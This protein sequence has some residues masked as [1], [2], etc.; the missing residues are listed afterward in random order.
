MR[1]TALRKI[2]TFEFGHPQMGS[3]FGGI[4]VNKPD[5]THIVDAG[6]KRTKLDNGVTIVTHD[7]GGAASTIGFYADAGVRYDPATAPGLTHLARHVLLSSNL[8]NA[9]FQIDRAFRMVGSAYG[10]AEINKRH[11]GVWALGNRTSWRVAVDQIA[12]SFAAPRYAESDNE[13]YRDNMDNQREELRWTQPR[14]YAVDELETVAFYKEPLGNPRMVRPET[15]DKCTHKYLLD[16]Y[17][18]YITP[19]RVTV[20]GVNVPHQ[21]LMASYGGQQ[22]PHSG[23]APHHERAAASLPITEDAKQFYAGKTKLEYENRAKEMGTRPDMEPEG[24]VAIGWLS[25]GA[26]VSAAK[27]AAGLIFREMLAIPAMQAFNATKSPVGLGIESFYRPYSTAGLV[28]YT[29]RSAPETLQ[30]DVEKA[31][32]MIPHDLV[33][34]LGAAKARAAATFFSE[35]LETDVDYA[36]FLGSS[37]WSAEE[38]LSAI[39]S[40]TVNHIAELS[41]LARKQAPSMFATGDVMHLPTLRKLV[42]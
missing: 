16:K 3:G 38:V 23:S 20:V 8:S 11:V 40:A 1:R 22:F 31:L 24:I 42:Q 26:D 12:P 37:K 10:H 9:Q 34:N 15:N 2:T 35:H 13:R 33:A 17:S 32:K 7:K 19:S 21:D 25:A 39:E 18:T 4:Y 14:V 29:V 30:A 5:S 6:V 28:G 41:E 27:Y 36:N